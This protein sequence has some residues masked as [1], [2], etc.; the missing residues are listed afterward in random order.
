MKKMIKHLSIL[1]ISILFTGF[2][3][4]AQTSAT[5]DNSKNSKVMHTYV[6]ERNIPGA[7]QFSPE[8]LKAI[9]QTSCAVLKEMGPEIQWLQSY[10]T[11]DKI[12]C[13]YKAENE[14]MLREHAQKGGFPINNVYE[15][16][17]VISPAT[18]N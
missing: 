2:A 1:A 8:K 3:A 6:I 18:A 14:A 10:V 11:G 15:V 4:M 17:T 9:S 16:S 12:F 7:G 13:V 5:S